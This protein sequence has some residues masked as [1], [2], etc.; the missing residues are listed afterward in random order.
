MIIDPDHRYYVTI[1]KYVLCWKLPQ[2]VV[3]ITQNLF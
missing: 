2:V 1:V 3:Q